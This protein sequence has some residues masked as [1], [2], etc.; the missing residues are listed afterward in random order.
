[1]VLVSLTLSPR[2]LRCVLLVFVT[3]FAIFDE[4][5]AGY[6]KETLRELLSAISSSPA[7]SANELRPHRGRLT[8]EATPGGFFDVRLDGDLR[9]STGSSAVGASTAWPCGEPLLDDCESE[10][11]SFFCAE[12]NDCSNF[13]EV[14]EFTERALLAVS[15]A[16]SMSADDGPENEEA[17]DN[18]DLGQAN[19]AALRPLK[20]PL[21]IHSNLTIFGGDWESRQMDWIRQFGFANQ[22]LN[23]NAPVLIDFLSGTRGE[24][25][26]NS[27]GGV[28]L[29]TA[30]FLFGQDYV[31]S[32]AI[33]DEE[34]R[35]GLIWQ[36]VS[37][38]SGA[39]YERYFGG[40]APHKYGSGLLHALLEGSAL[41]HVVNPLQ[42]RYH[43]SGLEKWHEDTDFPGEL[44]AACGEPTQHSIF[45]GDLNQT[46]GSIL[47]GCQGLTGASF[48]GCRAFNSGR[49]DE[50]I[51]KREAWAAAMGLARVQAAPSHIFGFAVPPILEQEAIQP[52]KQSLLDGLEVICEV[53]AGDLAGGGCGAP[54]PS[55]TKMQDM[56]AVGRFMECQGDDILYGAATSVL[57]MPTAAI[58]TLVSGGVG[59]VAG[60][61]LAT[62]YSNLRTALQ[63]L[64]LAEPAIGRTVRQLGY[65]IRS[66]QNRVAQ[67]NVDSKKQD[68]IFQAEAAQNMTNCITAQGS[69]SGTA[70]PWGAFG[71]AASAAATCGNAITQT[72]FADRLRDLQNENNRVEIDGLL[73]DFNRRFDDAATALQEQQIQLSQS[74][75]SIVR[76]LGII[77]SEKATAGRALNRALWYLSDEG[78]VA[79]AVEASRNLS[80][81]RYERA[82]DNAKRMAFLAKRSIEQRLGVYLSE[83][84]DDLPL[85][86]SPQRWESSL[87]ATSPINYQGLK[88][89]SGEDAGQFADQFIGDYVTKL[90]NVVE[91][92]RLENSFNE[93]HDISVVSLRDDVMHSR[94]TCEVPGPNLL[95]WS[96]EIFRAGNEM[97]A[98]GQWGTVGCVEVEDGGF[99]DCVRVKKVDAT[100]PFAGTDARLR[101]IPAVQI[102][103]GGSSCP[104]CSWNT[105]TTVGQ[106]LSLDPGVYRFS[107]YSSDIDTGGSPSGR[108]VVDEEA[109]SPIATGIIQ[110]DDFTWHRHFFTFEMDE[111]EEVVVGFYGVEGAG[112]ATTVAAPMLEKLGGLSS[113]LAMYA[114]TT[115]DRNIQAAACPDING[116]V[117]RRQWRRGCDLL[118]ADG[119]ASDCRKN[120]EQECYWE[121][122]FYI[123]QRAIEAGQQFSVA[124]F[125]KGNFNYRMQDVALNIIGSGV[126]ACED[127]Q[128]PQSCYGSGFVPISL[129]HQGPYIVRNYGGSDFRASLFPGRIEH[130]R[131]LASERYISNPVASADRELLQQYQRSELRG[132]PLD[133][134]F[135][136]RIWDDSAVD[137][138]SI[139]DVQL[140]L[141]YSYWTRNN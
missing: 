82:H 70:V 51:D 127:S 90:E 114:T 25:V 63:E 110:G 100:K 17:T 86:E 67:F 78:S 105:N 66:F 33:G 14:Q 140:V 129:L 39:N 38:V 46:F 93:G 32:I 62:A 72:R 48:N 41:H 97:P 115:E 20:L 104:N 79:D 134:T 130:A 3:R 52:T 94:A 13:P 1:M 45:G 96:S 35:T 27:E 73:I 23:P 12:I 138:N 108:V 80:Q 111:P 117:F 36:G 37:N 28:S 121:T 83:M 19:R 50:A 65:D 68:I 137:F 101:S 26:A 9:F 2:F 49:I 53:A 77:E 58:E 89:E 4:F 126:R 128:A 91:S 43:Y 47:C 40:L 124:G 87:C 57:K 133:G 60:G 123:S 92:Y 61:T 98:L 141:D 131:G 15:M 85:V 122:S 21:L 103:F 132:R 106:R 107:W 120:S 102:D 135:V 74:V 18:V 22:I 5:R 71:A 119:Y 59:D 7:L 75:E 30:H 69:A 125:A 95:F 29:P 109:L 54:P 84:V 56:E 8:F 99:A 55:V 118:C 116:D 64:A 81:E 34:Y 112:S 16:Y 42:L 88:S 136:V 31:P 10:D 113:E 11:P 44:D 139:E 6:R 76:E 24:I